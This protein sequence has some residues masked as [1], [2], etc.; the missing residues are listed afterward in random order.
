MSAVKTNGSTSA[1]FPLY[2]GTHQGCCLSPF[3]FDLA[4]EPLAIA[5]RDD[6]RTEGITRGNTTHKT[7]LYT[8]DL[9]LF[10]T[11]PR[12][13]IPDLLQLTQEFGSFSGYK[14]NLS[15]SLLFP[16]NDMS[17]SIDY[18]AFP[19]KIEYQSFKYLGVHVTSSFK[20]LKK[21][22]FDNVQEQT[23]KDLE[24]RSCPP[25]RWLAALSP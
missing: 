19:F 16:I 2:K 24:R 7:A 13:S 14:L 9:L 23:K 8:Y 1:Y 15:K 18:D 21:T 6:G 11:N 4:I 5:I 10:V 20:S 25:S 22:N 17:K 3:L 12:Q